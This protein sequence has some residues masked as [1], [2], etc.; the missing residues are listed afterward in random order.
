MDAKETLTYLYEHGHIICYADYKI[1][2]AEL[3]KP[4]IEHPDVQ[5]L[6]IQVETLSREKKELHRAL[7][8][9]EAAL[10][11]WS[12]DEIGEVKLKNVELQSENEHLIGVVESTRQ[13]Y[14]D[15]L[16]GTAE[17]K[18]QAENAKLRKAFLKI[19]ALDTP[20]NMD[21]D[22][23]DFDKIMYITEQALKG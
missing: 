18:L 14:A 9:T 23:N 16:A 1:I 17:A 11:R 4:I 15:L 2:C 22:T 21:S 8:H 6:I 10:A 7:G 5:R 12:N 3:D 20:I 19:K 13:D